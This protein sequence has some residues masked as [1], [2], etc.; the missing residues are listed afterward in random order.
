M[1]YLSAFFNPL[2]M[3]AA[4]EI[5]IANDHTGDGRGKGHALKLKLPIESFGLSRRFSA[6]YGF[7]VSFRE[8]FDAQHVA[9]P[10]FQAAIFFHGNGYRAIPPVPRHDD[11]LRKSGVLI[12]AH[13]LAKLGR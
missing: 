5:R 7:N 2:F 11:G 4:P 9:V 8:V 10:P 3:F 6:P 12:A 1:A 13:L